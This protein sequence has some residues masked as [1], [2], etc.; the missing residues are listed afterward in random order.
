MNFSS[1]W[2]IF[3]LLAWGY[4]LILTALSATLPKCTKNFFFLVK[5]E[6]FSGWVFLI[7][8]LGA[9]SWP[10]QLQQSSQ[11]L[12]K[13]FLEKYKTFFQYVSFW[14][15]EAWDWKV[16]QVAAYSATI[17]YLYNYFYIYIFICLF[18][19]I[20][21]LTKYLQNLTTKCTPK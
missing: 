5:Q 11:N 3:V 16:A 18:Y 14:F 13:T 4:K 12:G 15:C 17:Q 19:T 1:G 6:I 21:P 10:R 8:D 9:E 2:V 7:I 20:S